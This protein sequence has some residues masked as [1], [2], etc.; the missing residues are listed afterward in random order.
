MEEITTLSREREERVESVS[1]SLYE[2]VMTVNTRSKLH[3][4]KMLT[5]V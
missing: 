4:I 2:D 1:V 3:P 5:A